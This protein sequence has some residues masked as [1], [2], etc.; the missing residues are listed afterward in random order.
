MRTFSPIYLRSKVVVE[1][2]HKPLE[3]IVTKP[4]Y[5]ARIRLQRLLRLQQ[6]DISVVH[7]PGKQMYI[8]D[9]LSRS[10]N[11]T[12]EC[13]D[14]DDTSTDDIIRVHII[15]PATEEKL[16]Q[17]RNATEKDPELQA[18]KRRSKRVGHLTGKTHH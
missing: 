15:I 7:K 10:T 11:S 6:Y 3:A 12:Q 9:A 4:L 18:L 8:A 16:N 1:T 2:D 17:I 13:K 14:G 5:R